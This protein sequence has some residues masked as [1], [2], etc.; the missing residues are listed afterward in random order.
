[1]ATAYATIADGGYRNRPTLITKVTFPDG[2]SELPRRWRVHRVKAFPDGVTHKATEILEQN[3]HAGTGTH[4]NIGCPAGGKTGTTD[5]NT[6][7][8]FVGFTPRLSTA[9]WVGYPNDRTEMNGLYFGRNVDGGTY[10]ADIWGAYMKQA[11]GSF[12]GPF[13]QPK[14]PFQSSPFFGK[15]SRSGGGD[16]TSEGSTG[17]TPTTPTAPP[18]ASTPEPDAGTNGTGG[19][20]PF[21]PGAYE[22]P[23]QEPP[24]TGNGNGNGNGGDNGNGNDGTGGAAPPGTTAPI[25]GAT[26]DG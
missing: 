5:K 24:A 16:D 12:C 10:P 6:D 2:T 1:M 26:P 4:A 18:S 19:A 20:E 17:V 9:V 8:W 25:T 7:A 13:S 23:P 11:K 3:I 22:S 14:E 21:D 15:Y